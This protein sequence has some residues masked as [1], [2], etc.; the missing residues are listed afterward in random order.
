MAWELASAAGSLLQ[1]TSRLR[2][3]FSAERSH[4][5]LEQVDLAARREEIFGR[6]SHVLHTSR[7][8]TSNRRKRCDI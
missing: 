4:L 2:K 6:I 3:H 7:P 5:L 1:Q 8:G